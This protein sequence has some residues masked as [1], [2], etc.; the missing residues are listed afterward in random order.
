MKNSSRHS[1]LLS[2]QS[3]LRVLGA[4]K[5]QAFPSPGPFVLGPFCPQAFLSWIR[6]AL[7]GVSLLWQPAT[8]PL[9][10][11]LYCH[12]TWQIKFLLLLLRSIRINKYCLYF[13]KVINIWMQTC[14]I[15]I[16]RRH[17]HI[18][19]YQL[20]QCWCWSVEQL[21]EDDCYV[22]LPVDFLQK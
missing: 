6:P 3:R 12:F 5:R 22:L 15:T 10:M 21:N 9:R 11:H 7:M 13:T 18:Y 4:S 20:H 19:Y 1:T 17:I 16:V 8:V 14:I 2:A